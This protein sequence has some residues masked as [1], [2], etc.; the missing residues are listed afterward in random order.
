MAWSLAGI[1]IHVEK[2]G[3]SVESL[4]SQQNVLDATST[5]LGYYGAKSKAFSLGFKLI[6]DTAGSGSLTTLENAVKANASVNLVDDRSTTTSVRIMKLDS[7]RIQALNKT[8]PCYDCLA[9][10]VVV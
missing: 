5:T 1:T 10:L 7:E 3:G 8:L 2:Q 9:D 6:E 4:Y